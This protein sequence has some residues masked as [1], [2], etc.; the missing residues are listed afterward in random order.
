[1]NGKVAQ[2]HQLLWLLPRIELR[3]LIRAHH[4]VQRR[5]LPQRR[6]KITHRVDRVRPPGAP[7]LDVRRHEMAIALGR[8]PHHRQ[9]M[10]RGGQSVFRLMRRR[11]GRNKIDQVELQRLANFLGRAQ[12]PEMNRIETTAEQTYPHLI[13]ISRRVQARTCPV[14]RSTYLYVV[15]SLSPIG[16]RACSRLVE[17]PVSAPNPNSKPSVKRVD[18]LT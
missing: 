5:R 14:P 8:L 7:N 12:M 9:A 10:L 4:Q 13:L 2:P 11:R 3:K 6:D 16:P 18:A 17:I 1:M 15:N